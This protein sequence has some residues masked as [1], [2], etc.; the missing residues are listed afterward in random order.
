ML[1]LSNTTAAYL[2]GNILPGLTALIN[3]G[4]LFRMIYEVMHTQSE[5]ESLKAA[6]PKIKKYLI[7]MI[8]TTII[9]VLIITID[10]YY[11]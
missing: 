11:K 10:G 8:I 5:E 4:L 3:A 7:A 1:L 9:S 2:S 6:F